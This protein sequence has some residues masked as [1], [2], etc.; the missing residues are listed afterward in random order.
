[1]SSEAEKETTFFLNVKYLFDSDLEDMVALL[2]LGSFL[3]LVKYS[4][5]YRP[6]SVVLNY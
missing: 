6:E 1:M 2:C 5:S 4:N 3:L